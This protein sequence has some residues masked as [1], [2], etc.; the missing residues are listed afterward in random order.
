M[1]KLIA[2]LLL[3][4]GTWT[5]QAQDKFSS[6]KVL[7][8]D[9]NKCPVERMNGSLLDA[10]GMPDVY[11]VFSYRNVD[12]YATNYMKDC[13]EFPLKIN[14]IKPFKVENLEIPYTLT[15]MDFDSFGE[16]EM[17]QCVTRDLVFAN[18]TN[19]PSEVVLKNGE[20]EVVLHLKWY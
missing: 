17:I 8:I 4:S 12:Y 13:D 7:S 10:D 15:L 6:V 18:Y 14:L 5:A 3:L 1:K 9:V 19:Y 2:A 20:T 11:A 16:N